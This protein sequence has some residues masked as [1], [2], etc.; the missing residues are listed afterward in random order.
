MQFGVP[1]PKK[2]TAETPNLYNLTLLLKQKGKV[3]DVRSVKIGFR[4]IEIAKDGQMLINGKSTLLKGVNRHDHSPING[5][6]VS[7]EE[8]E[9]TYN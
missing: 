8:M 1:N 5:R 9:R 6:T 2:W 7:K 3:T 4:K